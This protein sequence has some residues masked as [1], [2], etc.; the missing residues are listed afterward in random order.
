MM[1]QKNELS[2]LRKV[3]SRDIMRYYVAYYDIEKNIL[4]AINSE[5]QAARVKALDRYLNKYMRIG[6][7]FTEK[8]ATK[9][10][11]IIDR[12]GKELNVN[13]L[14]VKF[15]EVRL[16][17]GKTKNVIVAASKLKWLVQNETI[18]MDNNNMKVL[19]AR[20]YEDYLVR[21]KSE[22]QRKLIEIDNVIENVFNHHD[23]IMNENW[24]KMRVFDMYLWSVYS[25]NEKQ[26]EKGT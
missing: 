13:E 9:I 18:I 24:F 23:K 22:F 2:D 12:F 7:N 14:S 3:E 5:D 4:R 16:L 25:E 15:K 21:W 17:S 10:I 19:H 8:S 26:I 11:E 20:D 6:R 1:K